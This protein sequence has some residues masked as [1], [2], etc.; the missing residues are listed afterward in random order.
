VVV[1]VKMPGD[2]TGE[3]ALERALLRR[4]AMRVALLE[5]KPPVS[6]PVVLWLIAPHVPSWLPKAH[7]LTPRG[8]GCYRVEA[9]S[10]EVVWV[11]ANELPLDEALLPLLVA[12]S[13]RKLVDL[14][15]WAMGR[16]PVAWVAR[17]L[18]H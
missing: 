7:Q 12:R 11:A 16:R 4:Q 15:R 9:G 1:E 17:L 5:R 2:H 13:G 6:E 3:H 14:V 8:Q 10:V 18:N